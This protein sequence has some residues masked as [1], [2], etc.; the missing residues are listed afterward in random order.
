MILT[1]SHSNGASP[2]DNP[3]CI[4]RPKSH[5]INEIR[6]PSTPKSAASTRTATAITSHESSAARL[7]NRRFNSLLLAEWQYSRKSSAE[8]AHHP[9]N[10]KENNRVCDVANLRHKTWEYGVRRKAAIV[11]GHCSKKCAG[12]Y[13]SQCSQNAKNFVVG[14]VRLTLAVPKYH[15]QIESANSN[16]YHCQ[17]D[18]HR[19]YASVNI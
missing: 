19:E 9:N 4:A 18:H 5:V 17:N 2:K 16:Q 8:A 12:Y 11:C 13:R 15:P 14:I 10:Y 1:G 6:L 3:T 7:R